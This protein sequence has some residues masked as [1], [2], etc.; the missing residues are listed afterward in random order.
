MEVFISWSGDRS[1]IVA[2]LLADLLRRLIHPAKPW[3]SAT[4][5]KKGDRWL[6]EIGDKLSK[7]SRGIVC[8]TPENQNSSWLLFEAGAL[9]K[10]I[11]D[12]RVCPVVLG[13]ALS[14][15]QGPLS[16]FQATTVG[17]ADVYALVLSLN[18]DLGKDAIEERIL[19]EEF[20]DKW[21]KFEARLAK[22]L[23]GVS[24]PS[25][26]AISGVLEALRTNGVSKPEIGTTAYFR[27][28]FESHG[29]YAAAA[30][31][32]KKRFFIFGRKNRKLFDKEHLDFFRVLGNRMRQGFDFRCLFLSPSA[33]AHV[34]DAAH[35]DAKFPDQLEA[36]IKRA[37]SLLRDASVEPDKVLREYKISR[38]SASV[39]VDDAVLFTPIEHTPAGVTRRLTKCGFTMTDSTTSLGKSILADFETVWNAGHPVPASP[40]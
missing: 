18:K 1:K 7:V 4:S 29:L 30:A 38:E 15:L 27:D 31:T 8:V 39:I 28:G 13:M 10:A 3:M 40:P 5:I 9:S 33:P 37:V 20:G 25:Q 16:Q 22:Q 19:D 26:D 35:E 23:E 32:A 21:P 6:R 2:T 24:I 34:L 11:D 17:R 12:S 14:D 36:C